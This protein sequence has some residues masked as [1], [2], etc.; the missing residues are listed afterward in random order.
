MILKKLCHV[1]CTKHFIT[2]KNSSLEYNNTKQSVYLS[3]W[4]A[5]DG[6]GGQKYSGIKTSNIQI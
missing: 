4:L 3:I 5:K 6:D 1:K 2:M